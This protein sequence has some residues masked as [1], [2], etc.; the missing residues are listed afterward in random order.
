MMMNPCV[1]S[2]MLYENSTTGAAEMAPNTILGQSVW[3]V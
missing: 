3:L 2:Q 1:L